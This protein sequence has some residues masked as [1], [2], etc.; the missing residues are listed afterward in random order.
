MIEYTPTSEAAI[1]AN[2]R[3]DTPRQNQGQMITESY[4]GF[5]RAEHDHGDPYM[6]ICDSSTGST[7]YFVRVGFK[8]PAGK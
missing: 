8:P 2:V 1:P 5:C 3:F 7:K 4:G 6:R